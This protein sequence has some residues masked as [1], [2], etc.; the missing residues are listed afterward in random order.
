MHWREEV[1]QRAHGVVPVQRTLAA[2]QAVQ[3]VRVRGGLGF[4][5]GDEDGETRWDGSCELSAAR[6]RKS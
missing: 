5:D 4:I 6:A 2:W 3:A 1:E